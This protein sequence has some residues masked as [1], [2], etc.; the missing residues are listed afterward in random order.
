[1]EIIS[2]QQERGKP[3]EDRGGTTYRTNEG[4]YK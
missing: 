1:M 2:K 4:Y 3:E